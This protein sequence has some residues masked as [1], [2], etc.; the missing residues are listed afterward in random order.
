MVFFSFRGVGRLT[1]IL[2]FGR[3]AMH[4]KRYVTYTLIQ[5]TI[6]SGCVSL[7]DPFSI[8]IYFEKVWHNKKHVK[9]KTA[10]KINGLNE[11]SYVDDQST[12]CK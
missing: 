6:K 5:N 9:N 8:F 12:K 10:I 11:K 7:Y 2:H 4:F 1:F 3:H